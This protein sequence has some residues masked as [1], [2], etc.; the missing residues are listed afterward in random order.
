L[1]SL[2]W[3]GALTG[4]NELFSWAVE[5]WA[6]VLRVQSVL[7]ERFYFG[8]AYS[9]VNCWANLYQIDYNPLYKGRACLQQDHSFLFS[10]SLLDFLERL[11]AQRVLLI[12]FGSL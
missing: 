1:V 10:L 9:V 6:T 12:W 7:Q 2:P 8:A 4:L 11:L 3:A 5:A